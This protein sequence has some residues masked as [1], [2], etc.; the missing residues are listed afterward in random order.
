MMAFI[1][2]TIVDKNYTALIICTANCLVGLF[3]I[4]HRK[5]FLCGLEFM[6]FI[7]SII[8]ISTGMYYA[9]SQEKAMTAEQVYMFSYCLGLFQGIAIMRMNKFVYRFLFSVIILVL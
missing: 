2:N 1:A 4:L 8:Y 3:V 6:V 5:K 7:V 9:Q